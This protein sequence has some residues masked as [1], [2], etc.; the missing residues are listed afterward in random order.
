MPQVQLSFGDFFWLSSVRPIAP[1]G[2][3]FAPDLQAWVPNADLDPDWLRVGTDIVGGTPVPTFNA[4]FT[5][6]GQTP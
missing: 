2:T 5:L 4:A 1:P 6:T 3:A